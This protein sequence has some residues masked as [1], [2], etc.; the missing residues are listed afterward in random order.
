MVYM[1]LLDEK[2]LG[3]IYLQVACEIRGHYRYCSHHKPSHWHFRSTKNVHPRII[4]EIC[5]CT[6]DIIARTYPAYSISRKDFDKF[7]T[8]QSL[9]F[10]F[11]LSACSR[12][13]KLELYPRDVIHHG[14][15]RYQIKED[16]WEAFQPYLRKLMVDVTDPVERKGDVVVIE[17][18]GVERYQ[19]LRFDFDGARYLAIFNEIAR[20]LRSMNFERVEVFLDDRR[21]GDRKGFEKMWTVIQHRT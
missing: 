15:R 9:H 4:L 12:D 6:A 20:E 13:I 14:F 11:P 21:S 2:V 7:A 1:H 10:G 8:G 17:A 16:D 18:L 3:W 5:Q 19:I